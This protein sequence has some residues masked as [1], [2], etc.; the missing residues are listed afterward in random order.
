MTRIITLLVVVGI[1]TCS[2]A[3][4]LDINPNVK[5]RYIRSQELQLN[6]LSAYQYEFPAEKGFDYIFNLG[7]EEK[8]LV[9]YLK[10]TDMQLKPVADIVDSIPGK[11]TNLK[12]RVQ[13]SGTYYINLGFT[14]KSG[15]LPKLDTEFTLIRREI[16]D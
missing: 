11:D 2:Q 10:V 15:R 6:N 13:K 5:W 7:Y 9:T 1:F 16:V 8:G 12:F 4:V 14:D 3:Q